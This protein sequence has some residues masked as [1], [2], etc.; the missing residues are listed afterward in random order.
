MKLKGIALSGIAVLGI[1]GC[2]I[3]NVNVSTRFGG[4]ELNIGGRIENIPDNR[5]SYFNE[6]FPSQ[7][8]EPR[9][10]VLPRGEVPTIPEYR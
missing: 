10:Y 3:D 8:A 2:A 6:D 5:D 1:S 7:A 4:P 9:G